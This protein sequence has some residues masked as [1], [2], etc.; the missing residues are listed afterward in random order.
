MDKKTVSGSAIAFLLCLCVIAPAWGDSFSF[1]SDKVLVVNGSRK[2]F[3]I[4]VTT[5]PPPTATTPTLKNAYQELRDGGVT[6]I[7]T[8]INTAWDS[9]GIALEKSYEDAAYAHGLRCQLYLR[10]LARSN[11]AATDAQLK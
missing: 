4:G 9:A 2:V 1:N 6:F 10:D 5:P 11:T 7:R 3:P 8:G